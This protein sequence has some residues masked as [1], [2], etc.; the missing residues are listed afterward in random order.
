M[1]EGKSALKLLTCKPRIK[2]P[3]RRPWRKWEDPIRMDIK[4]IDVYM[5]NW[6]DSY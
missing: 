1:E 4:G 6:I 2:L 3:L 5:R